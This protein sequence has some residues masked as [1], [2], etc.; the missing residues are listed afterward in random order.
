[1]IE[2]DIGMRVN[3]ILDKLKNVKFDIILTDL[4]GNNEI[5]GTTTF[6]DCYI[7][8]IRYNRDYTVSKVVSADVLIKCPNVDTIRGSTSQ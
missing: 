8:G 7:T 4:N 3:M 1:M 2:C 5:Y 6:H